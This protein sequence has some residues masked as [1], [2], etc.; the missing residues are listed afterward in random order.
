MISDE[1]GP[2]AGECLEAVVYSLTDNTVKLKVKRDL[3]FDPKWIDSL[4]SEIMFER[5]YPSLVQFIQS[6]NLVRL[7][8]ILIE[9]HNPKEN[10]LGF[11]PLMGW[12]KSNNTR[13]QIQLKFDS[14]DQAIEYVKKSKLDYIIIPAK[15]RKFKIKSYSNY[16]K[17][18][19]LK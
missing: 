18:N 17:Y 9:G 2:V 5:N 10:N 14:M 11:D 7:N 13:K 4:N 19:R 3:K 6:K 12:R 16:F 15:E 8:K 1:K